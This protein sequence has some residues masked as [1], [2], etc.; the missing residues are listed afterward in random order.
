ME[1]LF[2][3]R[4]LLPHNTGTDGDFFFHGTVETKLLRFRDHN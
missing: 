4:Q 3:S 2:F 1:P